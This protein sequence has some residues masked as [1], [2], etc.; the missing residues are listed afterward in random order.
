MNKMGSADSAELHIVC[1][2]VF[3]S[4]EIKIDKKSIDIIIYQHYQ[5]SGNYQY[6]CRTIR[7]PYASKQKFFEAKEA[8]AEKKS[9][10]YS[11][12]DYLN[13]PVFKFFYKKFHDSVVSEK[14]GIGN[15][16]QFVWDKNKAQ[17][18]SRGV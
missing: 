7:K 1:T 12:Y 9:K 11:L 18:Y 15:H 10:E 6:Y 3:N 14:K 8:D 16:C 2:A 4:F 13:Y 5:Y 17:Y